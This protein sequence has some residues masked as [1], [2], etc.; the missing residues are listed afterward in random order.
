MNRY[1]AFFLRISYLLRIAYL[2]S[3]LSSLNKTIF[4]YNHTMLMN[5]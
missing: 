2:I 4:L 5:I 3:P 1:H